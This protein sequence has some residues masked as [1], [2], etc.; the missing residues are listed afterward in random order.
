[1]CLAISVVSLPLGAQWPLLLPMEI[2]CFVV[3]FSLASCDPQ[4]MVNQHSRESRDDGCG[5]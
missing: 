4:V 2:N 3:L 5:G 1:M